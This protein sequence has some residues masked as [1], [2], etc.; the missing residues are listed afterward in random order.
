MYL[1]PEKYGL[2]LITGYSG[3]WFKKKSYSSE[4]SDQDLLR[5]KIKVQVTAYETKSDDPS[6][7]EIPLVEVAI[8]S[9]EFQDIF[10]EA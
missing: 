2:G 5:E 1:N 4:L 9:S 10:G 3:D 6:L 8:D 7:I